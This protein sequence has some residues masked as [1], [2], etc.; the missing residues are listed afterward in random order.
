MNRN[1]LTPKTGVTPIATAS[2]SQIARRRS[3]RIFLNAPIGISGEDRLKCSFAMPAKAIGLN[4]H[5]AALQITRDLVV[6]SV[7]RLKNQ[8]GVQVSARVV[9]QF[10]ATQGISTYGVEFAEEEKASNFWG[11]SF[12]SN[13]DE[14]LASRSLTSPRSVAPTRREG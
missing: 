14:R 1:H 10:T 11:I 9:A 12:P 2:R 7:V 13:S 6:G 3:R 4:K 8:R 5:G